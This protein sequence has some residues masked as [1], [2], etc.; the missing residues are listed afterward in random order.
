MNECS[1]NS[2][3]AFFMGGVKSRSSKYGTCVI[4]VVRF[5]YLSTSE[6]VEVLFCS[7][8]L[9]IPFSFCESSSST[10][11][12]SDLSRGFWFS[13]LSLDSVFVVV[14]TSTEPVELVLPSPTVLLEIARGFVCNHKKDIFKSENLTCGSIC[15]SGR[16]EGLDRHMKDGEVLVLSLRNINGLNYSF[17][18][19]K[20]IFLP[21]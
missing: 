4:F 10:V 14:S 18:D 1:V 2:R 15:N 12:L 5:S 20:P 3:E 8:E 6:S 19:G 9:Q 13:V 11:L 7:S 17:Q 16:G 21:I